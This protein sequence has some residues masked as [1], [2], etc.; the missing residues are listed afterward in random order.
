ML[1]QVE[2]LENDDFDTFLRLVNDSGNSSNKW[3]Q[4]SY[5]IKNPVEQGVNLALALTEDYIN[6]IGKG[7]CRVH[8]GGFA[9]TIQVFLP[10]ESIDK[11]IKLMQSVFGEFSVLV[12]KIRPYGSLH[13]NSIM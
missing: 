9:G 11:Y 2:A 8:G 12:L 3:L 7:A 5:T 4:N 1:E 6:K 10:N 13:L